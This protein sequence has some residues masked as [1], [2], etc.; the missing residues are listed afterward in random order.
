HWTFSPVVDINY[1]FNCP[2]CNNRAIS[3]SPQ[4]IVK[5]ARAF[6]E[7]VQE[8]GYMVTA[9]KHFP[10]QGLDDR[11]SHFV[12]TEN[13]LSF[14]KWMETYGFVY[15]EMIKAGTPSIMVAHS[16]LKCFEEDID[17]FFGAPPAV[18]S[19][20]LMTDL[21]KGKLG[22]DG[23]IVSDAMSMIG[24][25]ARVEKLEDIGV[26]FLKCG[27]DMILFPE[28][29]DFENI[30]QAVNN[31]QLSYD[32]L[33]DACIRVLKLKEK[34]RLFESQTAIE[35]EIVV[36]NNFNQI[37]QKIAD[38]S[39]KIVRDYNNIFP[40][41]L[42]KGSKV[43]FLNMVE[44]FFHKE[45]TGK[46][47][48]A[49]KQAFV[50][51]GYQVDEIFTAKH[52]E[53]KEI[54]DNYDLICIN[55]KMSAQDYHG[56][57]LRVGWNNIMLFWRGYVLQHPRCVFISFGDPYKLYDFPYVKEYINAFSCVDAT[58]RAVVKAILGEIELTAKNP[59]ELK[60]YF[61][62]EV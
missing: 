10:G 55:C 12:T 39:I 45:P 34:A 6:I 16:S 23:C 25:A 31:G 46:E 53:V 42:K 15:K 7:G 22:F 58:Q 52:K 44:P 41:E 51:R 48:S 26:K 11:N 17:A 21:L 8:N 47:F 56:A 60:G 20:S 3:D 27:G 62:R 38:E 28:P 2:E 33:K 59:V 14:E 24:V 36:D 5:I 29:T 4:Q 40:L 50:E 18:L 1:N 19:K 37:A 13:T 30:L 9:C 35:S 49:M 32:R 57:T 61:N 54:M 43:L